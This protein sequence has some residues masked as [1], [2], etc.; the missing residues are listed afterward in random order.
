MPAMRATHPLAGSGPPPVT[1]S[2]LRMPRLT[3]HA[4]VERVGAHLANPTAA[5]S[6]VR[7][8]GGPGDAEA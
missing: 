8:S 5:S 4:R 1:G 7:R 6:G 3:R 2:C